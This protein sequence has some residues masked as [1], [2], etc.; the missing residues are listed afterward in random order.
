MAKLH[1]IKLSVGSESIEALTSWQQGRSAERRRLG[2]DPRPRHITRMWPRREA[3]LLEGGSIY[4]VVSGVLLVRQRIE[5]LDE[6]IGDDG[7]RRCA[8]VL[9]PE[10]IRVEPRPRGP[11]QGWRYLKPE[12]APP[13]MTVR[14]FEEAQLPFE[15]R[16][17]LTKFG[18]IR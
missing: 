7:I 2:L 10:L 16:E 1:L 4:W 17:E 9:N 5:A 6:V 13:D 14:G 8:I 11:F 12:D 18:I 15:L 3:E